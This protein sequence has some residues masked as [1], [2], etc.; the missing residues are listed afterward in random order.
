MIYGIDFHPNRHI[1]YYRSDS[2]AIYFNF[3]K[4]FDANIRHGIEEEFSEISY[5]NNSFVRS[6]AMNMNHKTLIV[7]FYA[8]RDK[9]ELNVTLK[10]LR[11]STEVI[12]EFQ[13]LVSD[14]LDANA[15]YASIGQQEFTVWQKQDSDEKQNNLTQSYMTSD[16]TNEKIS[17]NGLR[18]NNRYKDY[19]KVLALNETE[20]NNSLDCEFNLDELPEELKKKF[21]ELQLKFQNGYLTEKGLKNFRRRL[22]QLYVNQICNYEKTVK[23]FDTT[24]SAFGWE[25]EK[26][27]SDIE[28]SITKAKVKANLIGSDHQMI[29][30][31]LMDSYADS[32]RHVNYLYNQVFGIEMRKVP[33]HM[34]HFIDIDVMTRLQTAFGYHFDLTSSHQ[35]RSSDDM[36]F[37]FAY[38]YYLMSELKTLNVSQVF[39]RFDTDGSRYLTIQIID[40]FKFLS[41][42]LN[43][44]IS[45]ITNDI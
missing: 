15:S 33:A 22:I 14:N 27:F 41:V 16:K 35:I 25:R 45:D 38:N 34:A 44:I 39:D 24:I 17:I 30:R 29:G 40:W 21:K 23:A 6:A 2:K 18:E 31:H 19:P 37:S 1:Y 5:Q 42:I 10:A 12:M 9:D 13:A 26:T 36:Q 43:I 8:D 4:Y 11:N 28:Q 7:L 20:F 3:N 32:L